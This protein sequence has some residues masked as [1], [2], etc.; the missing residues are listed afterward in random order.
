MK[1]SEYARVAGM[2]GA[3]GTIIGLLLWA[4]LSSAGRAGDWLIIA[5]VFALP[6]VFALVGLARRQTYT[7]AWTSMLAVIY[8]SFT[9][10]EFLI[11]GGTPGLIVTLVASSV[12]FAGATVYPRL[13][14]R[15][16]TARV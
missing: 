1:Y 3:L 11:T 16:E 12:L 9:L 7:A 5:A 2:A 8:M 14:Y 15:E 6:L 13:R 4:G 10:A